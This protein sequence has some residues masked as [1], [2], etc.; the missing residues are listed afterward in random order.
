[1]VNYVLY[2]SALGY[3]LFDVKESEEIG[4]EVETVQVGP[5]PLRRFGGC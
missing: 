3:A 1:M 4:I 5:A 2:E